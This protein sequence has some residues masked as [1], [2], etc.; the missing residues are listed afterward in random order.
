MVSNEP[1]INMTRLKQGKVRGGVLVRGPS[2][3]NVDPHCNTHRLGSLVI[4]IS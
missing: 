4:N 3:E 2:H 1:I